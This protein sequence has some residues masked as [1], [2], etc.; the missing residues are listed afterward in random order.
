[1]CADL[2]LALFTH[3]QTHMLT[4]PDVISGIY[5]CKIDRQKV[6]YIIFELGACRRNSSGKISENAGDKSRVR[7][8]GAFMIFRAKQRRLFGDTK[9]SQRKLRA[10]ERENVLSKVC[11]DRGVQISAS[12][13]LFNLL[14]THSQRLTEKKRQIFSVVVVP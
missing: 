7:A 1:M 6:I 9:C 13:S 5:L 12:N 14:R 11:A 8:E 3:T 2:L 4:H 10:S